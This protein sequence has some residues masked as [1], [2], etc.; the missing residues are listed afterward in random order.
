MPEIP[1][2][3][4]DILLQ[5]IDYLLKIPGIEY[6]RRTGSPLSKPMCAGLV[7]TSRCNLSCPYCFMDTDNEFEDKLSLD[8]IK[9]LL[10]FLSGWGVKQLT[11]TGGEPLLDPDLFKVIRHAKSRGMTV[12]FATNGTLLNP[13]NRRK[14]AESGTDRVSVSIDGVGDTHDKLHGVGTYEKAL[15]GFE[16]L[17]EIPGIDL[18]INT[19]LLSSN[20]DEI[21]RLYDMASSK[22]AWFNVMPL[23]LDHVTAVRKKEIDGETAQDNW[24][25]PVQ[26]RQLDEVLD[27]LKKIKRR[28]G[29]LLNSDTFLE[30]VKQYYRNQGQVERKCKIAAYSMGFAGDGSVV[31]CGELGVL[32]NIRDNTPREIWKSE[33]FRNARLRMRSCSKCLLNCQY[34]PP[35]T[36]L[37][38]DFVIYPGMRRLY[39]QEYKKK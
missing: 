27:N 18:R 20:L 34:T 32:G 38:K 23:T 16:G 6:S 17:A 4:K 24:I 30:L 26:Y 31:V 11:I 14:I 22:K 2:T 19:I 28:R 12:G 5:G 21:M 37:V 7:L 9:N 36:D 39:C 10:D 33:K 8:E 3:R 15:E 13:Q 1:K 35:I 25:K 29:Y